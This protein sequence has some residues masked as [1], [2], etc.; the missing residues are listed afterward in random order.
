MV[1]GKSLLAGI[2]VL[3][4]CSGNTINTRLKENKKLGIAE[5]SFKSSYEQYNDSCY[6]YNVCMSRTL[7]NSYIVYSVNGREITVEIKGNYHYVF[8]HYAVESWGII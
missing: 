5:I 8:Y 1:K 4:A 6:V 7:E 2:I 3:T